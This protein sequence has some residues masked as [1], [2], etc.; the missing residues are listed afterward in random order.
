M[1]KIKIYINLLL[2][3]AFLFFTIGCEHEILLSELPEVVPEDKV[4][5][6]IFTRANSYQLPETRAVG[7][8]SEVGKTPWVLVFKGNNASSALFVEAVQ[9]FEFVGK[10]YVLLTR[11]EAGSKY[12][13]LILANPQENFYYGDMHTGYEFN[14]ANFMTKLTVGGTTLS[15]ATANLLS[16][17]LAVP[18]LSVIPYSGDGEVI[19]M[20][21]L[22]QVDK[23][24]QTTKIANEDGTSLQLIREVAKVVI[25]NQAS[26]FKFK[27]I[28]A[29]VNVPGQGRLHNLDGSVMDNRSN[30]TEYRYDD[31]YSSLLVAANDVTGGESTEDNPVYLY[32][33]DILND[34]YFIIQGTYEGQDYYYKVGI[35]NDGLQ[36]MDL[37]RNNAY[38]FTVVKANGPGYDTVEDAKVSKASNTGLSYSVLVD[39]G[40]IY[41]VVANNDYYLGVSN[42]VFFAY[43]DLTVDYDAF[44][45]ITNNGTVFPGSNRISD[46]R[47]EVDYA[48][49]LVSPIDGKISIVNSGTTDP[50]FTTVVV[51]VKPYLQYY[52]DC[53]TDPTGTIQRKNANVTL[54]LGNLIQQV[55]INRRSAISAGGETIKYMP[56]INTYPTIREVN[57]YCLSGTVDETARSWIKLRPSSGED[58][59]DTD[60]ITVDDGRIFIEVLPNTGIERRGVVYL[61]TMNN[62]GS[63]SGRMTQRIKIDITQLAGNIAT[64]T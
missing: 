45:V 44:K 30:L 20:S 36:P 4:K 18:S 11:Q 42:S 22:L 15:E 14:V 8:E 31:A 1:S 26:S 48:F 6:E 13:L 21:Y 32:E 57:Y 27:G 54:Q 34:T 38:T 60:K 56:T 47:V 58:R 41:D 64:D 51:K 17:P 35:I 63:P 28:T 10:R 59:N 52:D 23:I 40:N 5:I 61:T 3:L 19:P 55:H 12:H 46:N 49:E 2:G 50:N 16:E 43:S 9:A 33:S 29:V 7:D 62:I 25:V 53:Q 39:D 24:D 37:L